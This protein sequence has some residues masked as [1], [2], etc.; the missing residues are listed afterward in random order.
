MT[1]TA[2]WTER[3]AQASHALWTHYW[4]PESN[5]FLDRVPFEP[6]PDAAFNYWW[7][8]HG[9]DALLDAF[10]RDRDPIHLERAAQLLEGIRA[11]NHGRIINDYFDDMEW[12][13][14]A[15]LRAFDAGHDTTF[16]D[17]ALELWR[18]IKL[19]WNDH[20]GGGLAWRK[21]QLDYKNTPANGPAVILAARLHQRFHDPEDLQWAKRIWR[22]LESHLIDPASGFVWD[23]MNGRGDGQVDTSAYTYCQGVVIGAALELHAITPEP[24]LLE[25]ARRTMQASRDRLCQAN[26]PVLRNEGGG[27]GGLFKGI[28]VRYLTQYAITT[29]NPDALGW[30]HSNAQHSHPDARGLLGQDW[31][32]APESPLDLSVALSGVFLFEALAKLEAAGLLASV[33]GS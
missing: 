33:G 23:G 28:L 24:R 20:C 1:L 3:A 19:G 11:R 6:K 25:V 21:I 2:R 26:T 30:L 31:L 10:E 13:A 12:L 14:L 27:D 4:N 17:A 29:Q 16:K 18:D 9:L 32:Q 15:C 7:M 22:W 8:A 5:L